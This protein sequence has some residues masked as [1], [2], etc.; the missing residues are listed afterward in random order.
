[1][2]PGMLRHDIS[3]SFIIIFFWPRYSI[4]EERKNYAMQYK[5]VQK[6]S[7][8]EPYSSSSSNIIIIKRQWV[9]VASAGPHASLHL[10]PDR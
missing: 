4:P 8:N 2:S 7:W 6:S 9:A 5:K 1:M 3:L 10:A